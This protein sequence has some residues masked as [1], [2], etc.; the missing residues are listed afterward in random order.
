MECNGTASPNPVIVWRKDGS[1]IRRETISYDLNNFFLYSRLN[2]S[3][4]KVVD[5][6]VY[7]CEFTNIDGS[8][9]SNNATVTIYRK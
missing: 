5:E 8:T 7:Q 9:I 3:H 2:I 6:G 1:P 4:A